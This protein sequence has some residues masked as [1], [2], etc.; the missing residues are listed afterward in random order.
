YAVWLW[1]TARL[2]TEG[3]SRACAPPKISANTTTPPTTTAA[4]LRPSRVGAACGGAGDSTGLMSE[5]AG[6][7]AS[8]PGRPRGTRCPCTSAGP[9]A[10]L[11]GPGRASDRRWTRC[12]EADPGR[13]AGRR[14]DALLLRTRRRCSDPSARRR[15]SEE[16]RPA[17]RRVDRRRRRTARRA[18]LS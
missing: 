8:T 13:R 7:P 12:C 9:T 15:R 5:P 4:T 3:P 14:A 17:V 10:V 1:I 18:R 6:Y 11:R 2:I 16:R